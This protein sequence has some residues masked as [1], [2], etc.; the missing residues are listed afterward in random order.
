MVQLLNL[1][2]NAGI[3][4]GLLMLSRGLYQFGRY[5]WHRFIDRQYETTHKKKKSK[6]KR[7]RHKSPSPDSSDSEDSSSYYSDSYSE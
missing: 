3:I 5:R 6:S 1:L 4:I 2:S 7:K